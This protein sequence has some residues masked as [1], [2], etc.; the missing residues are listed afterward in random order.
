MEQELEKR[1]KLNIETKNK[2]LDLNNLGLTNLNFLRDNDFKHLEILWC[3]ENNI[4]IVIDNLYEICPNLIELCVHKNKLKYLPDILPINLKIICCKYN[5]LEFLPDYFPP[6]L[7]ELHVHFNNLECVNLENL[8]NLR[9]VSL[10]D[11]K[12]KKISG[13]P[14]NI[15]SLNFHNNKVKEIDKLPRC[16]TQMNCRN[17]P[18]LKIKCDISYIENLHI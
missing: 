2:K 5:E 13:L 17:N 8:D 15:K 9:M 10:Q 14:K 16:I 6:Y 1:I 18:D 4:E 7:E 11:N 3:H 12:I